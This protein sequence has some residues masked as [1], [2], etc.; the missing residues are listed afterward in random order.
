M[1]ERTL[2]AFH[3]DGSPKPVVAALAALRAYLDA[4]GS[5]P[6]E[7]RLEDDPETG[8]RYVYRASDALLLGGKKVD[9]GGVSFEAA[10][11]AELFITWSDPNGFRIWAS[12]ALTATIDL[13][14]IFSSDVPR[15]L[16]TARSDG[17][18]VPS[19]GRT[20][21]EIT[22]KLDSGGYVVR[23]ANPPQRA[24]DYDI[25][26]G[27]FFTQTNGRKDSASGFGVTNEGGVPLWTAFQGLGGVDVLGYPVTRRFELD[28]FMVQ[29]FQKSVLQWHADQNTFAF[30]NTFDVLHD[31]GYDGWLQ[32]YRQTPPPLDTAADAGLA[33]DQITARHVALLDTAPA[34]LKTQF[35]ADSNWLDH[36]GLP[37]AIQESSNSVVVRAQRATLQYWKEAVPWAAKGSVSVANGGDLAKEAGVFPWLAVTPENAPR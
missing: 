28:G 30:L 8:V 25:S 3:L 18:P 19:L 6:G 16:T 33:F 4:T 11:P 15:D 7:L 14:Q 17:Q 36:Y 35:L 1:R 31:R 21:N 2:G 23:V 5:P 34:A 26:G 20:A 22:L 9:G 32:V 27:H 37:V 12:T 24:A 29:A 10:G 13:G